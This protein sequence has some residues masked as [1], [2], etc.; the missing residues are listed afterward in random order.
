MKNSKYSKVL[1]LLIGITLGGSH[2]AFAQQIPLFSQYQFNK[3]IYNPAVAGSDEFIDA[4]L[5][6]R[7]QWRGI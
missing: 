1:F 7:Y 4:R 6:Q 5:I 3:Y 2:L